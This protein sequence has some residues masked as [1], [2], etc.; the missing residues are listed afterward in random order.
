MTICSQTDIEQIDKIRRWIREERNIRSWSG[1]RLAAEA[2]KAA[3]RRGIPCR[4][5]QQSIASFEL[6]KNKS[7]PAWVDLL[8]AAFDDNP[9]LGAVQRVNSMKIFQTEK[10]CPEK[11]PPET[12]L[13]RILLGLLAPMDVNPHDVWALKQKIATSLAKKLPIAIAQPQLYADN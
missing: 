11:I 5:R 9:P 10:P 2:H 1:R 8:A 12:D 13:R 6:G 3:S 4:V 7:I